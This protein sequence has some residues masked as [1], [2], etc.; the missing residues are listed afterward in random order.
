MTRTFPSTSRRGFLTAVS[1]AL[2]ASYLLATENAP[3]MVKI[4]QFDGTGKKTG[5]AELPKVIKPT[6]NG[7]SSSTPC[8]ST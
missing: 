2:G 1:A 4:V 5:V 8:S 6:R 7:R 3:K